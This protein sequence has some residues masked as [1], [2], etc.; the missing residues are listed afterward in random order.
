MKSMSISWTCDFAVCDLWCPKLISHTGTR[1]HLHGRAEAVLSSISAN[2]IYYHLKPTFLPPQPVTPPDTCSLFKLLKMVNVS[3]IP[4]TFPTASQLRNDPSSTI[5][6]WRSV[7]D[8]T[9]SHREKQIF[10]VRGWGR[11]TREPLSKGFYKNGVS[12][13][14]KTRACTLLG[15]PWVRR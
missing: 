12:W 7:R 15:T 8:V 5:K 11:G 1:E 2:G 4:G 10:E 13:H 9:T 6:D 3:C 14:F